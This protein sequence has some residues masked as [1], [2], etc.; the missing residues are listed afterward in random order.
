MNE[1]KSE[2]IEIVDISKAIYASLSFDSDQKLNA[3]LNLP[4]RGQVDNELLAL[5][6]QYLFL[7]AFRL[8][9][10]A[11]EMANVRNGLDVEFSEE[12]SPEGPLPRT[13]SILLNNEFSTVTITGA[14]PAHGKDGFSEL[15]F[16]WQ[17]Q[18]GAE[19]SHGN[20]NLKKLN[21]FPTAQQDQLLATIYD[22]TAGRPGTS[23]QGKVIKPNSGRPLTLK[24][25]ENTIKR[26]NDESDP[27]K[28]Y[29][30]AKKSGIAAFK[31][32]LNNDPKTLNQL[33]IKDTITINGDIDYSVGDLSDED[34]GCGAINIVVKGDV[35]G[36][37]SLKSKGYVSVSGTFEG[38]KIIAKDVK[39][40]VINAGSQ[41][42]AE[43]QVVI[44]TSIKAKAQGRVVTLKRAS[45]DS[46]LIGL[47]QVVLDKGADCLSLTV[48]TRD[49]Q[50]NTCNF[51]GRTKVILG[52]EL[53]DQEQKIIQEHDE[54]TKSLKNSFTEIK[55]IG[56]S[57][58]FNFR[59]L[60]V[61]IVQGIPSATAEC[62]EQLN[63]INEELETILHI[64]NRPLSPKLINQ[65]YSLSNY[66]GDQ[67][68]ADSIL[69]KVEALIAPLQTLQSNL[70][71]RCKMLR[72]VEATDSLMDGLRQEAEFLRAQFETPKF[73]SNTSEVF[74][75][76]GRHGLLINSSTIPEA[77]FQ[78]SYELNSETGIS[79][80]VLVFDSSF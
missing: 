26:Q 19:D 51:S 71:K 44:G 20:S 33:A 53:F 16:N 24:I 50:A 14:L 5:A 38:Q 23:A 76:C 41:V 3:H 32:L 72:I 43:D 36:A 61:F 67:Q 77:S 28:T 69:P 35:R 31:T 17:K 58:L 1:K 37:F 60:K 4:Q 27:S 79:D 11:V 40:N 74:V 34:L 78:V 45:N 25:D 22:H 73:L 13:V 52:Q 49:F 42:L 21:T 12:D 2:D 9:F 55:K 80:G 46:E 65:C 56:E 47:E 75:Q 66:I 62:R 18:A 64:M 8:H 70:H 59:Q 48:R 63:Q 57:V 15:H 10:P 39:I 68:A 6:L 30:Y 7:K 54:A 29:L